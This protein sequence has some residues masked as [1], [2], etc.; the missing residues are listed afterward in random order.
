MEKIKAAVPSLSSFTIFV[1]FKFWHRLNTK[2]FEIMRSLSL[3]CFPF[4]NLLQLGI[5]NI[6]TI[7]VSILPIPTIIFINQ[8]SQSYTRFFRRDIL[9][10]QSFRDDIC[11]FWSDIPLTFFVLILL[12]LQKWRQVDYLIPDVLRTCYVFLWNKMLPIPSWEYSHRNR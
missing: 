7:V 5:L 6:L 12:I 2:K 10:R 11:Q 3:P 9:T 4:Y 8:I 1:T